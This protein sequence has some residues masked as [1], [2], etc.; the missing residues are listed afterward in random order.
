MKWEEI[1][2]P[3]RHDERNVRGLYEI[4]ESQPEVIIR[5]ILYDNR[6]NRLGDQS[7]TIIYR[8]VQIHGKWAQNIS[9]ILEITDK[10]LSH[11]DA[12]KRC[13]LYCD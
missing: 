6:R 8:S 10:V 3:Y 1:K 9:D 12:V 2:P 13:R 5:G 11:E 4:I 7:H